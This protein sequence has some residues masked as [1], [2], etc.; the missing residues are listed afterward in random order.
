MSGSP[1]EVAIIHCLGHMLAV[2]QETKGGRL[3]LYR[4][5]VQQALNDVHDGR[6]RKAACVLPVHLSDAASCA[7][8]DVHGTC[9]AG[10]RDGWTMT[11]SGERAPGTP[12]GRATASGG[13]NNPSNI[14]AYASGW[15]TGF[16]FISKNQTFWFGSITASIV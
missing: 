9:R 13:P 16:E 14:A 3:G 10:M 11:G 8:G 4:R 12:A 15:T 5:V 2:A 7:L 1:T 6:T